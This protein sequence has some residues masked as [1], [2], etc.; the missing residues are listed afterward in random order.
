MARPIRI[1]GDIAYVALTQG[2]VAVID[3]VDLPLVEGRNWSVLRSKRR[4]AAYAVRVEQR[5]GRQAMILMHRVI[6]GTP[7]DM[8]TDHKDGDGL[9]NRRANLRTCTHAQNQINKPVRR[10]CRSGI[11]GA[12]WDGRAR[13]WRAEIMIQ[14]RRKWL[15]HFDSPEAARDAY[16]RAAADLHR[17]FR[18]QP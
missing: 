11:K 1:D 3:A 9:N 2:F 14:G 12:G 5:D 10:D 15:G 4:N 18:R 8:Q 16:D 17:D 13:R 7:N 6:A